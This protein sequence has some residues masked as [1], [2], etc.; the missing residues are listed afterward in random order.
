M[1]KPTQTHAAA[2][3]N[4][5]NSEQEANAVPVPNKNNSPQEKN[6]TTEETDQTIKDILQ[7]N[8]FS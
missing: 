3:D 8:P 2:K 1:T 7:R 6:P 4:F 5:W